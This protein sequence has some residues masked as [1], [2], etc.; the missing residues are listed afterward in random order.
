[1]SALNQIKENVFSIFTFS[2]VASYFACQGYYL[3]FNLDISSFLSVED[4]IMIFAKWIWLSGVV[5]IILVLFV[6]RVLNKIDEFTF[7]NSWL[8]KTIGNTIYKRTIFILIPLLIVVAILLCRYETFRDI[9]IALFG[10]GFFIFFLVVIVFA[11]ISIFR[12]KT[13]VK[14][15]G[16]NDWAS[17]I[18]FVYFFVIIIPLSGGIYAASHTPNEDVVL[19]ADNQIINTKDSAHVIYIGKTHDYIFIHNKK[20][21][22]TKAYNLS[23]ITFLEFERK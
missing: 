1:M 15:L 7:S 21:K 16:L 4:L 11:I 20:L 6:R 3:S 17:I 19:K 8:N 22:K 18:A 12:E 9:F 23:S 13:D 5:S 14:T 2:L 10:L